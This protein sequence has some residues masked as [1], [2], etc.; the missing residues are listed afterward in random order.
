MDRPEGPPQGTARDASRD[1]EI[2][3][4]EDLAPRRDVEGGRKITLGERAPESPPGASAGG[5]PTS[6]R[7]A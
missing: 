3:R 2:V 5:S 7:E 4:L 1:D 6:G